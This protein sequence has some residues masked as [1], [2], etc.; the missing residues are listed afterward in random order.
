MCLPSISGG[1]F[2]SHQHRVCVYACV[3]VGVCLSVCVCVCVCLSGWEGDF[4][5]LSTSMCSFA[6][7]PQA[8]ASK[9]GLDG[10]SQE[11]KNKQ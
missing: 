4:G 5:L 9:G 3:S 10:T 6:E 11:H 2:R 1:P 7:S 8:G